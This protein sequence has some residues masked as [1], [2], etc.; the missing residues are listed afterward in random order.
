MLAKI[1][2]VITVM[3][4]L[5]LASTDIGIR[6]KQSVG[7]KGYLMCDG[8]PAADVRVKL[9]DIDRVVSMD[10]KLDDGKTDARG[11]FEL[12]GATREISTIDPK[13]YVYHDCNDG[14]KPCQRRFGIMIPD[15]FVTEGE[16]PSRFYDAGIIE[17]A[18]EF[19]GETRDCIH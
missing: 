3:A 6:T 14:W 9:Y 16:I 4:L 7:V 17:L 19:S 2:F 15:K 13:L 1:S 8:K 18:G 5:N 10:D 12:S 11:Y